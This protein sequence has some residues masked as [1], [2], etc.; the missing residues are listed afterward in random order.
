MEFAG[1]ADRKIVMYGADDAPAA[2]L[3]A[4]DVLPALTE[5]ARSGAGAW[6]RHHSARAVLE[7]LMDPLPSAT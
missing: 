7:R 1:G 3:R 2:A 6:R 5:A 4:L